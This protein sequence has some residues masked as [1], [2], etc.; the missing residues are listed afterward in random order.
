MEVIEIVT[1]RVSL[2]SPP[3]TPSASAPFGA[4][5]CARVEKSSF[6]VVLV[7]VVTRIGG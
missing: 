3:Y 4:R 7:E 1:S 6:L 2:R 5:A